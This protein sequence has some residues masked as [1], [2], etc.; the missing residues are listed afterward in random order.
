MPADAWLVTSHVLKEFAL[1]C[2]CVELDRLQL[3]STF[4]ATR[5][6]RRTP[7]IPLLARLAER[8]MRVSMG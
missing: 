3:T 4:D 5:T 2:V 6:S 1:L 7:G 8:R